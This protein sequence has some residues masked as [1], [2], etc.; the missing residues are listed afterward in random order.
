MMDSN[1]GYRNT[2]NWNTGN[3][4]TGYFNTTTPDS[5][6]AF[7][8]TCSRSDWEAAEK[9]RW[10]YEP[11][12]TTWVSDAK[13]TDKEKTENPTFHTCGGYLRIND[14]RE[15]WRKAYESASD[16]DIQKVRKLPNFDYDV[17]EEITGLNLRVDGDSTCEGRVIEIDGV[18]YEL[19]KISE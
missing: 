12:P 3:W 10:I 9:P 15:E 8:N 5:V 17:F 2:G 4:N 19:K 11:S 14:W 7:N 18:K 6:N 16:E 13:M 1:T